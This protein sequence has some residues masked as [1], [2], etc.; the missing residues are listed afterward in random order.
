LRNLIPSHLP[1]PNDKISKNVHN[2]KYLEHSFLDRVG[3]ARS[4][5]ILFWFRLRYTHT[6][7]FAQSRRLFG[8]GE[9]FEFS[10]CPTY[11]K[12]L[13]SLSLRQF[14]VAPPN[15][16]RADHDDVF[17]Q[18]LTGVGRREENSAP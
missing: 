7:P 12:A 3:R 13:V 9:I 14:A 18:Y 4:I 11:C 6:H 5:L 1:S 8:A 2:W 10:S 17:E 15:I 16:S